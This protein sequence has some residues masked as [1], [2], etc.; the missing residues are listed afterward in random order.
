VAN[1]DSEGTVIV[2][3]GDSI[4]AGYGVGQGLAFPALISERL[5]VSVVNAGVDGDTTRDA[6]A[7]LERDVLERDPRIVIVEFGGNDF[8]KNVEKQETFTNLDSIVG[9]ITE[10]GAMVILLE[11][12]IGLLRDEYLA[13]FKRVA[14]KHR[15][16]LVRNFMA[17]IFGN[18]KLTQDGIHPNA[19]GHAMIADRVVAQ[20]VPLLREAERSRAGKRQPP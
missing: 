10:R 14:K 16:L 18:H 7:R 5:D 11:M 15:A 2:C 19:Q 13:G 1:L 20:L 12:R 9:R 8:R 4:T 6:L 3:F 17:G